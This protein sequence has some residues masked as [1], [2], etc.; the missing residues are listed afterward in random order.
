M[1]LDVYV[2][3]QI[4]K[5]LG[6]VGLGDTMVMIRLEAED[7]TAN[8]WLIITLE[9]RGVIKEYS[10]RIWSIL[11]GGGSRIDARDIATSFEEE[12]KTK[13]LEEFLR[14]EVSEES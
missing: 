12:V 11:F 14:K 13:A 5:Y 3:E 6:D 10:Y 8:D 7:P 2:M 4:K 9:N 1:S